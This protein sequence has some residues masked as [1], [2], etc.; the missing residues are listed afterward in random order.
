MTNIRKY[1]TNGTFEL[2]HAPS[3]FRTGDDGAYSLRVKVIR[4]SEGGNYHF[5]NEVFSREEI[6][7]LEAEVSKNRDNETSVNLRSNLGKLRRFLDS[8]THK[9]PLVRL[10]NQFVVSI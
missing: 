2:S 8:K 6:E 3:N 7:G 5:D 9:S 1:L 10:W 4:R